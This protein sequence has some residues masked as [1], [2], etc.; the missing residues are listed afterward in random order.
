MAKFGHGGKNS[1]RCD[2]AVLDIDAALIDMSSATAV[3]DVLKHA[4]ILAEIKR[5][6]SNADYVRTTQVEPL[7]RFAT[8]IDTMGLFWDGV[9]PRVFWKEYDGQQTTIR[10]GPLALLPRPGKLIKAK[11]LTYEDLRPPESLLDVFSRV[12]DV[13]HAASISLEER[14]EVLLQLILA[15]IYDEHQGEGSPKDPL[16]FQDFEAVGTSD[17]QASLDLNAALSS[18]VGF[19]SAHLPKAIDDRFRVKNDALARCG[20]I[21]AS[22][23]MT[24]ANKEVIQTFY[25]KFAKDLYRWDLAQYFTPPTVTDFIVEV[26]NPVA[27][28]VVK[29]PAC[30]SADF[31][32][33]TFHRSRAKKI[34][35]AADMTFGADNDAKAVQIAV[36]NMLLNGDGKTNIKEEDSLSAVA[37]NRERSIQDKQFRPQQFHAMVCNPP[38]GLKIVEKRRSVLQWFDLGHLWTRDKITGVYKQLTDILDQQEKGLLFAEVCVREARAGGRIAI[39]LPNGYLG[40]RSERY[41]A[42]REWLL[43]HCRVVSI[44]GFPRFTFKTSGADVSASVVYLEKREK[45]LADSSA[46]T[47]YMFNVEL[48][49]N[50]GWSV[51]DKNALPQFVRSETDGSFFVG[52]DGRKVIRSD[53]EA[54]LADLRSSPAVSHFGWLTR[55]LNLPPAGGTPLGWAKA[56]SV[57]TGDRHKTL[58]PKRHSRKYAALIGDIAKQDHVHLTDLFDVL[59]QGKSS[60]SKVVNRVIDAEYHYVDIDNIGAGEYRTSTM[61]GWQLPQRA[62]H[63]AEAMEVYVG[64]IWSSV[65]KWCLIGENPLPNTVVTNGCHRLRLKPGKKE[66]L[67]DACVFFCSEAYTT[68]MRALARGSDGLAEIH[69][70]DLQLVLVPLIKDQDARAKLQPFVEGL[71]AGQST[72][73]GT[74][75]N[76]L[77]QRGLKLPTPAARSHH[78]VLV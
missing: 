34:R 56:I 40:N 21:M 46:D 19:Y 44:C 5:D 51:G 73:K 2:L 67:L 69:E 39:I 68:Q 36:L 41:V 31:L 50:V 20:E 27:G 58:D 62:K 11:A 33:A 26:L 48:I 4:V 6:D 54:V 71:V 35:N 23:L 16:A 49:E 10:S 28:E 75:T 57:V 65:S 37:K 8:R 53:F 76:L 74:V 42:F 38:F 9:T 14:Y 43:R 1:F 59:P 32:V 22:H 25:M 47:G 72:L 77:A 17:K 13:L 61:R 15:K 70:D 60:D 45:P 24:A 3:A 63:F 78:S 18:A 29:D 7:L 64:S 52:E 12:E 55:G 66:H 30:G